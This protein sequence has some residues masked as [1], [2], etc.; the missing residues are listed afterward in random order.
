M[1]VPNTETATAPNNRNNDVIFN[2]CAPF[3]NYISEINNTQADS[4]DF[5]VVMSMYSLI[6]Y[7]DQKHQKGCGNAMEIK[8]LQRITTLLLIFLLITIIVFLSN[9]SR[10]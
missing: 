3:V 8:Q 5:D 2:S 9:L 1:E 6:K 7:S 10:K 4:Q